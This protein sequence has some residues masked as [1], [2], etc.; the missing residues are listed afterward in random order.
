MIRFYQ[1]HISSHSAP[2]CRYYPTCSA[3]TAEAIRL[4]GFFR[5]SWMGFRRILRCNPF[6]EGG[7]DPVPG[8]ALEKK[9]REAELLRR[10]HA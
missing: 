1:R 2:H 7:V 4:Y 6:H 9:L 3:Y 10:N 8:S 5:G